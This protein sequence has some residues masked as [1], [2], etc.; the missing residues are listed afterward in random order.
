MLSNSRGLNSQFVNFEQIQQQFDESTG[1]NQSRVEMVGNH[2]PEFDSGHFDP[3]LQYLPH[4][5]P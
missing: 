1:L 4:Q 5:I 2:D 3:N